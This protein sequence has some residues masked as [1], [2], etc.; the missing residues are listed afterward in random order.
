VTQ[1]VPLWPRMMTLETL[2]DTCERGDTETL[3]RIIKRGGSQLNALVTPQEEEKPP[4]TPLMIS[5]IN[6]HTA[7]TRILIGAGADLNAVC[8]RDRETALHVCSSRGYTD[9]VRELIDAGANIEAAD[10]IGRSPL[11]VSSLFDHPECTELLLN[12]RADCEHCMS[13]HNP[14][15]TPL[16]AAALS[17]S[18]R[19]TRLLCEAGARVNARTRDGATPIMVGCQHGNLRAVMVLSSYGAARQSAGFK[20]CLPTT[21]TWAED[22]AVRSGN[23]DLVKWLRASAD[24]SPLHHV[25][26]LAPDRA[27]LLLRSGRFSP[28]RGPVS[29]AEVA[30]KYLE[31]NPTASLVVNASKPWSPTRHE[32]WGRPQRALATAL[33]MIGSQLRMRYGGALL[34]AW[35]THVMPHIVVWDLEFPVVLRGPRRHLRPPPAPRAFGGT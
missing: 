32:L 2:G 30:R 25:E 28:T 16:Y 12:A 5:I 11:L 31:S 14:G 24:Y 15:A 17:G 20:G 13:K 22:L 7:C 4:M 8:G 21:G 35:I 23:K 34:D 19:C 3:K 26:V 29:A 18:S 10:A 9:T 33:L 27:L 1:R 6:G